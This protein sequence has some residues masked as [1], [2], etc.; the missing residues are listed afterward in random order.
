MIIRFIYALRN[1]VF[2][3]GVIHLLYLGGFALAT[4]KYQELNA[5]VILDLHFLWP[6]IYTSSG[7]FILSGAIGLA[8]FFFYYNKT[9]R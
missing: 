7:V 3:F 5:A 4:G 1:T 8:V 9:H 2:T 6:W